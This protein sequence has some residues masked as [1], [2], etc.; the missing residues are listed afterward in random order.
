MVLTI[1]EIDCREGILQAVDRDYY[2]SFD[3]AA[4]HTLREFVPVLKD[5]VARRKFKVGVCD[6][7]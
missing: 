3:D 1:G 7:Q 2:D 4:Q 5:L 6:C